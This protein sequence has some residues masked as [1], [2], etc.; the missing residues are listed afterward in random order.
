[1]EHLARQSLEESDRLF[2]VYRPQTLTESATLWRIVNKLIEQLPPNYSAVI[3][4]H[5]LDG[6]SCEE[7]SAIMNISVSNVKV[8]LHRSRKALKEIITRNNLQE[9]LK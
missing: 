1:M 3:N 6:Y 9:E 5:Y 8:L 4:L 2:G 7:I